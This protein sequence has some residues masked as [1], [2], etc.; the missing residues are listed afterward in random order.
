MQENTSQS[1]EFPEN[2]PTDLKQ[3]IK[4]YLEERTCQI[5]GAIL[6][7]IQLKEGDIAWIGAE[8]QN[9]KPVLQIQRITQEGCTL[10]TYNIF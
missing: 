2:L 5:G 6:H 3:Q 9:G 7:D 4:T 1:T 10:A 8:C